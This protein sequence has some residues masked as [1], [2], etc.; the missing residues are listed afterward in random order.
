MTQL[1]RG[2]GLVECMIA[3]LLFVSSATALLSVTYRWQFHIERAANHE[4]DTDNQLWLAAR[5]NTITLPRYLA[6]NSEAAAL[7]EQTLGQ[8]ISLLVVNPRKIPP[9]ATSVS[10][11][12][13]T[14][15]KSDY[16]T[17]EFSVE[18]GE[19]APTTMSVN[20]NRP[21]SYPIPSTIPLPSP[22]HHN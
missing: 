8:P 20:V 6:L 11:Q 1:K 10:N 12:A 4:H 18:S 22:S 21:L 2:M 7:A 15:I 17:L 14:L 13:V 3:T 5:L 16:A 9:V 19:Q